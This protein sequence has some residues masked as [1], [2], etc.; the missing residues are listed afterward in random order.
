MV[1][2]IIKAEKEESIGKLRKVFCEIIQGIVYEDRCLFKLSKVID[3]NRTCKECILQ[4]I[5]NFKKGKKKSKGIRDLKKSKR[6]LKKK[7]E[8]NGFS[9]DESSG[10]VENQGCSQIS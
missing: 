2:K 10:N 8:A 4:E 5:E 9:N 7:G 6:I 1:Q 3:G